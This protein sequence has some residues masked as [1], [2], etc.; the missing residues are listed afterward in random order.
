MNQKTAVPA[1]SVKNATVRNMLVHAGCCTANMSLLFCSMC[2]HFPS[3]AQESQ[4]AIKRAACIEAKFFVRRFS[5]L[6]CPW[7]GWERRRE[8]GL[9]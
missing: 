2:L 3:G 9:C 5:D 1:P 4:D 7:E 8:C 6:V